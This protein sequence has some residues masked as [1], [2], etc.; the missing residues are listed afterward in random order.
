MNKYYVPIVKCKLGE[1]RA[2]EK[3]DDSVKN[4][5]IPL[6]EIPL[7]KKEEPT[8]RLINSFWPNRKFFFY[9]SLDWFD[10]EPEELPAFIQK[11][12]VP[13]CNNSLGVPVIDLSYVGTVEDW[14]AFAKNGVAIRLRNN[15][16]GAIE[17]TLNALFNITELRRENTDLVLDLQYISP[18]DLFA[19]TSMLKAAFSDLDNASG[20]RSIIIAGVS[21]PKQISSIEG[22]KIH[23]F[24]RVETELYAL[25]LK[26]SHRFNFNYIYSDYGP[27]DIED[28]PFVVGMSPNFKIKY[29]IFDEYLYIKGL[30]I[31]KGGLDIGNVRELAKILVDSDDFSG[32]SFSW[33]DQKIYEIAMGLSN[34]PGNLTTWVSYAMNHHITFIVR[35]I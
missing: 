17:D 7:S 9:F 5:T 31:K 22:K 13:V 34:S 30:P 32:E 28:I 27:T 35:Q 12:V 3:L 20:F 11:Y 23:H 33:G 15:E 29:T 25:S 14:G 10:S 19:K 8:V 24:R 26:L 1:Q 16:F 6:I 4:I 18:D 21:F 2:L